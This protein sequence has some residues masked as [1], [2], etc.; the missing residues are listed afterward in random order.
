ML[1]K[2]WA[3][4]VT[5]ISTITFLPLEIYELI[6]RPHRKIAKAVILVINIAILIYL[7]MNLRKSG[8]EQTMTGVASPAE[9]GQG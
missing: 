4:Y 3:E 2:R 1:R 5:V 7:V 8:R 6:F 9:A